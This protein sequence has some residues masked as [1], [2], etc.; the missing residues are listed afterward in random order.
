MKVVQSKL[1]ATAV[2]M[3]MCFA[4]VLA[5]CQN[6]SA[7]VVPMEQDAA[8]GGLGVSRAAAAVFM[9]EENETIYV[10]GGSSNGYGG[11]SLDTVLIYDIGLPFTTTR[12]TIMPTG[13]RDVAYAEGMDGKFYIFGGYNATLGTRTDLTQIYNPQS[14][15]WSTGADIPV[16]PYNSA[17]A[18][19]TDGTIYLFG[20]Y[21]SMNS[22]L[23]YNPTS[24]SW[25]YGADLITP[26][27]GIRTAV[28]N[29]TAIFVIGG[30][31]GAVCTPTVEIYNPVADSWSTADSLNTA[32]NYAGAAFARNGYVYE[33]SG[34]DGWAYDA[35]P[36]LTS[37]ERY[38][39]E[40]DSWSTIG[41]T[42]TTARTHFGVVS[43]DMGRIFVVGGY[44]PAPTST[45]IGTIEMLLMSTFDTDDV[46]TLRIVSPSEGS[47]V[48]GNV[49]VQVEINNPMIDV[50]QVDLYVDGVLYESQPNM[51]TVTS[52]TFI[53]DTSGLSEESSHKLMVRGILESP[54]FGAVREDSVTVTVSSVSTNERIEQLEQELANDIADLQNQIDILQNATDNLNASTLQEISDLQDQI[55]T[56]QDQLNSLQGTTG[57]AKDSAAS[58]N[59][60][61]MIGMIVAIIVLVLVVINIMMSRSKKTQMP[62]MPPQ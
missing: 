34:A 38:D 22:T 33:I 37:I 31:T 11:Q 46:S 9:H 7:I 29:D 60:F 40:M 5:L 47:Y 35:N 43:D 55:Q 20:G 12:G 23:I 8:I 21:N 17:A 15:S 62:P 45:T 6:A 58:A 61:A 53:W 24:D 1:L 27:F 41:A 3:V 28:V 13:M 56:L 57:T 14:D 54:L 10:I 52:W 25:I 32:R 51:F 42:L 2:A 39:I 44:Q 36:G 16:V 4:S 19:G 26:R 30:A 18:T 49:I 48:S 59:L 50:M